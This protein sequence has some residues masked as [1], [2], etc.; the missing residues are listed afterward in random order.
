MERWT[1]EAGPER[2]VNFHWNGQT[3][4]ALRTETSGNPKTTNY[5]HL[6][7]TYSISQ[8]VALVV[9]HRTPLAIITIARSSTGT[10]IFYK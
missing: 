10:Y 8:P 9:S 2:P 3:V 4:L 7:K 5:A 6:Y 1:E